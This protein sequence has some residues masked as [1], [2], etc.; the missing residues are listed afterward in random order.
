M[1]A[2]RIQ[3]TC[4]CNCKKKIIQHCNFPPQFPIR[5]RSCYRFLWSLAIPIGSPEL[6]HAPWIACSFSCSFV[7]IVLLSWSGPLR[8]TFYRPLLSSQLH[9]LLTILVLVFSSLTH[10]IPTIPIGPAF[11]YAQRPCVITCQQC[12]SIR[13]RMKLNFKQCTYL[14][15]NHRPP[16][17]N[18]AY[19]HG[20]FW[21]SYLSRSRHCN[22]P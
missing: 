22:L 4:P 20:A 11:S 7:W 2:S 17:Q 19:M 18:D 6:D 1:R 3:T 8:L 16:T 14:R 21:N 13:Y 5:R 10:V 9:F 15:V 12:S